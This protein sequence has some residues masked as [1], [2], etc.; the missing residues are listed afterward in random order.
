[1]LLFK[2]TNG[3]LGMTENFVFR[4][5]KANSNLDATL[6]FLICCQKANACFGIPFKILYFGVKERIGSCRQM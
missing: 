1:M 3:R 4:G 5:Q 2:K 6:N